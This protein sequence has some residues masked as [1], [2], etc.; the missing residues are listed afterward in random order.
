MGKRRQP[1]AAPPPQ[2]SQPPQKRERRLAAE[3]ATISTGPS[4]QPVPPGPSNDHA[5]AMT[6]EQINSLVDVIVDKVCARLEGKGKEDLAQPDESPNTS[7]TSTLQQALA[8]LT[9]DITAAHPVGAGGCLP[10]AGHMQTTLHLQNGQEAIPLGANISASVRGKIWADEF[11]SFGQLINPSLGNDYSVQ[12]VQNTMQLN[13]KQNNRGIFT[14]DQ[15]AQAFA[16]YSSSYLEA[17]KDQAIPLIKYG[18][19]IREMAKQYP[20][21]FAWRNYDE[22]FRQAR[23]VTKWPWD[24][25]C[26][27]LYI[28]SVSQAIADMSI[29]RSGFGGS[30][31]QSGGRTFARRPAQWPQR[32]RFTGPSSQQRT[33]LHPA[34]RDDNGRAGGSSIDARNDGTRPVASNINADQGTHPTQN[35]NR[36]II[37]A[38][39]TML[40]TVCCMALA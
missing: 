1:T 2:Q 17:H 16:I 28:K 10:Q 31:T 27:E 5:V 29:H 33:P 22:S 37:S 35:A 38:D 40:L 32:S 25:I 15:W 13:L 7:T 30:S 9:A 11:I 20:S 8:H 24:I 19:N 26:H 4:A 18:F 12:I 39:E 34:P 23:A 6:P 14:I 21:P 36:Y 3:S